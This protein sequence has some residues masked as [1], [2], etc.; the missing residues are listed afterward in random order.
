MSSHLMFVIF[1]CYA[2][3][4]MNKYHDYHINTNDKSIE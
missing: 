1:S 2:I 4:V 3:I